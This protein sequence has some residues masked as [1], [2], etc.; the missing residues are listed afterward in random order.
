[1]AHN[2]YGRRRLFCEGLPPLLFTENETN[3]QRLYGEDNSSTYVKDGIHDYI[4]QGRKEAVNPALVGSKAA[5]HY[6]VTV[7]SG[8][9]HSIRLRLTDGEGSAD[10]FGGPFDT[11]VARRRQEADEFYR[12]R[13][14]RSFGRCAVYPAPGIRRTAV[15]QAI[16]SLRSGSLVAW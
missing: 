8:E 13:G 5:A 6:V 7:A 10:M 1:M 2:Y 4:V 3:A 12:E 11:I 9:T 14:R 16:L 15:E